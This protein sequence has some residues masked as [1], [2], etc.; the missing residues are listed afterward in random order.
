MPFI[1]LWALSLILYLAT[2]NNA[3]MNKVV[4]IF[5]ALIYVYLNYILKVVKLSFF[6]D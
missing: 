3:V 4:K 5:K 1:A 2:V 6:E